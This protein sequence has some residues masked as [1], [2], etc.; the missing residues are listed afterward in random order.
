[1]GKIECEICGSGDII[2]DNGL[3]VCQYCG[4]KYTLEEARKLMIDGT[5]QVQGTV[6]ND[7]TEKKPHLLEM[8]NS[9]LSGADGEG[10]GAIEYANK[11]LE[12]DSKN[13]DASDKTSS[14]LQVED[15]FFNKFENDNTLPHEF[16]SNIL[17]KLSDK[18]LF[19]IAL[20]SKIIENNALPTPDEIKAIIDFTNENDTDYCDLILHQEDVSDIIIRSQLDKRLAALTDRERRV[21]EL[22]FGLADGKQRLLEEV[23]KELNTTPERIRQIEAKALRKLRHP[24]R[25]KR[26]KDFL[27]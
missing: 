1:M 6:K 25:S 5:V 12:I 14:R 13:P 2:K 10:E 11:A 26:I 4:C 3:F 7:E 20:N 21:L 9:E 27:E 8:A 22:R 23:A 24:S 18:E 19:V 16:L 15:I 17:N